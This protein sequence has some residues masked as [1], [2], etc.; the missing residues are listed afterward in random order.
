MLWN[1]TAR[2][3]PGGTLGNIHSVPQYLGCVPELYISPF[4]NIH[5]V[6]Y[7]C[8]KVSSDLMIC[9]LMSHPNLNPCVVFQCWNFEMI[10]LL[11]YLFFICTSS[12]LHFLVFMSSVFLT[13]FCHS[14]SLGG[15]NGGK[16]LYQ[17]NDER[18]KR[19]QCSFQ[20]YNFVWGQVTRA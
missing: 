14:L 13:A 18:T 15:C 8:I 9:V 12:L 6:C 10:V 2:N 1:N 11:F 19:L 3:P 16:R 5:I 7:S 20:M 17:V 4:W